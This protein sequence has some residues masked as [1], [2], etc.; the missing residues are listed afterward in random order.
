MEIK[1]LKLE[2]T[3]EITFKRIGDERGYFME[4]Y[5]KKLFAKYGLQ[6]DWIQENQSLS[7]RLHTIRG[8]HFQAPPFAQAKLVRVVQGE[9]FDVF[10]DLRKDSATFG[11]WDGINLSAENCASVYIPRGFAHGF[12][13][14]TENAIVQYKV[15]NAYAPEAERGI[16]WNDTNITIDWKANEPLLS[17]KDAIL[18]F[19]RDL[20]SPF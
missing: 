3:F 9:I 6:T 18:P 1:P 5:S 20:V 12:C 19:F 17:G 10:V 14:L 4:T 7:A 16:R 15:D 11:Q 2:G 13:T 8:L